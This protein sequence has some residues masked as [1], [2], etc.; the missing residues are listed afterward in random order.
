VRR[1]REWPKD[2]VDPLRR[3]CH[4][5]EEDDLFHGDCDRQMLRNQ[6]NPW[7]RRTLDELGEMAWHGS[8]IVGYEDPTGGCREGKYLRIEQ[9]PKTGFGGSLKI[10]ARF[11][12]ENRLDDDLIEVCVRLKKKA[13]WR[14]RASASFL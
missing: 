5:P 2:Q 8:D 9:P 6:E 12:T 7:A 4:R 3:L 14:C 10:D 13:H 1:F 11:S